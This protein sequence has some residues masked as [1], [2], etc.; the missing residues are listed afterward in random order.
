M[1]F[2][3]KN[4]VLFIFIFCIYFISCKEE[5]KALDKFV[6]PRIVQTMKFDTIGNYECKFLEGTQH[7][8]I[9]K[10]PFEKSITFLYDTTNG[11]KTIKQDSTFYKDYNPDY[12]S[13][14]DSLKHD[15]LQVILSNKPLSYVHRFQNQN[16]KIIIG[17]EYFPCFIVNET[18]ND[19]LLEGKDGFVFAIQLAQDSNKHWFPIE[20]RAMDFCGNGYFNLIIH[21][22]EFA[23]IKI[24]KYSGTY[25]TKLKLFL[26]NGDCTYTSNEIDGYINYSQFYLNKKSYDYER[27]VKYKSKEVYGYTLKDFE[28]EDN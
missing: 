4:K 21:P 27:F 5:N 28:N 12:K 17:Y 23:I 11:Y 8:F 6:I 14:S 2:S 16:D 18:K 7:Y 9:S 22:N 15:G 19:K 25:K 13:L 24:N 3:I 10:Y 20:M 1:R 26:I